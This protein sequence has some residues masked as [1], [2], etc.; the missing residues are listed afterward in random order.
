MGLCKAGGGNR[1]GGQGKTL[2]QRAGGIEQLHGSGHSSSA[3]A[4]GLLGCCSETQGLIF[5]CSDFFRMLCG[6]TVEKNHC[7]A[8]GSTAALEG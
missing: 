4:Q 2:P 1:V 7:N 5:G 8:M 6:S 3:A